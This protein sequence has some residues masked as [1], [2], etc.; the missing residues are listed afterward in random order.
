MRNR[1]KVSLAVFFVGINFSSRERRHGCESLYLFENF[2]V[3]SPLRI[4][5]EHVCDH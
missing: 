1:A 4:A 2:H 3:E 5:P